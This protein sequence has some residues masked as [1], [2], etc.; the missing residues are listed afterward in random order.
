MAACESTLPARTITSSARGLTRD[1]R[2][3]PDLASP[4]L[5]IVAAGANGATTA[6]VQMTGTSMAAPHVTGSVALVL[7]K[8]HKSVTAAQVNT[9]QIRTALHRTCQGFNARH[10]SELGFGVLDTLAF[11]EWF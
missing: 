7:S 2:A 11:F 1:G 9:V 5:D 4:G 10:N 3:K 6:T 8:R